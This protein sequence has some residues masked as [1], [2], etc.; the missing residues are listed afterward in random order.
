MVRTLNWPL[1]FERVGG[2]RVSASPVHTFALGAEFS[3][4]SDRPSDRLKRTEPNRTKLNPT[5]DS[6]LE[7]NS[8]LTQRNFASFFTR[9]ASDKCNRF[10]A[11]LRSPSIALISSFEGPRAAAGEWAC[12]NRRVRSQFSHDPSERFVGF[13]NSSSR[14]ER[15]TNSSD[16]GQ[17]SRPRA[18]RSS[19]QTE[20][21]RTTAKQSSRRLAKTKQKRPK[22]AE[23]WR[24]S[25]DTR[26]T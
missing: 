13:V 18:D 19:A 12:P 3:P 14:V 17:V 22:V 2:T 25:L 8:T 15:P 16:R 26:E 1:R 11:S 10:V 5:W 21:N 4:T 23:T 9:L 24:K 7:L 6:D 20:P